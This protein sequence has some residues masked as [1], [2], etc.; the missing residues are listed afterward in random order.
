[1]PS[2][3]P[4][5]ELD[6]LQHHV[7]AQRTIA[8]AQT[9]WW[10]FGD[11]EGRAFVFVHGFRGDHHGLLPIVAQLPEYRI[12]VPDLPGFGES[13]PLND[14]S[15]SSYGSWLVEFVNEVAPGAIVLGHSFG[16]IVV[17]AAASAG[18][19]SEQLVLVNPIGAP[20]LEGPKAVLSK[21]ALG[22]YKLAASLP[23]RAGGAVLS[24]PPI[25]R[26]MSIV[27]AHTKDRSTRRWIHAQH[28]EYFSKFASRESVLGA[29]DTSIRNTVAQFAPAIAQRTLLI[30]AE[31]DDITPL[32]KQRVLETLFPDA[33]LSVVHDVGHLIHYERP[34]EAAATIRAWL[35]G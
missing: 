25:V 7:A 35:K 10:E 8:G 30:A 17:A 31:N 9:H 33:A 22:Y 32:K 4:Y 26:A 28:D 23:D 21:I 6:A 20:A 18:L 14:L 29:F 13:Q 11:P 12:I 24:A 2:Q 19:A 5:P 15:A 27:M 3:S 34:R 16:S 1:M